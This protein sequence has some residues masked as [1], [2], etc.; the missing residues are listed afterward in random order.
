MPGLSR[1]QLTDAYRGAAIVRGSTL[2]GTVHTSTGRPPTPR[3]DYPTG[4]AGPVVRTLK[5]SEATLEQ[6]WEALES[7]AWEHWRTPAELA[8]F[9]L[10]WLAEHDPA[11]APRLAGQQGRHFAFG[12]GGLLRRPVNGDWAGQGTAEYRTAAALLG[13]RAARSRA[14]GNPDEAID[15]AFRRQIAAAGPLSRHD[16]AWWSGLGLTRVDACLARLDLPGETGPDGRSYHDLPD[17]PPPAV[18][19]G[20]RLLPE[21]DALLCAFDPSARAR[22]VSP[23]HY[24]VLHLTMFRGS[25]IDRGDSTLAGAVAALAA[26]LD[27]RI[28]TVAFGCPCVARLK[29]LAATPHEKLTATGITFMLPASRRRAGVGATRSQESPWPPPTSPPRPPTP[30]GGCRRTTIHCPN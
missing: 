17:A 28:G 25:R 27:V 11:A 26:A 9:L 15:E 2:R 8:G 13:D 29:A 22:F 10:D 23:E 30:S 5:P 3:G 7:H 16:L 12:H 4:A 21:Y 20:V 14:V 24:E 1:D 19:A 6:V 18:L